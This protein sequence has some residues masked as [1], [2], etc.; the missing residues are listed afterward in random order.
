MKTYQVA[1]FPRGV[2]TNPTMVLTARSEADAVAKAIQM[3]RGRGCDVEPATLS[4]SEQ[5]PRILQRYP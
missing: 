2:S 5:K 4:V 1:G 3:L